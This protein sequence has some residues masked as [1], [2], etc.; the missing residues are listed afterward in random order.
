MI[1][2]K[3][4]IKQE[5]EKEESFDIQKSQGYLQFQKGNNIII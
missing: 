3:K 2:L 4:K 1:G 5:V